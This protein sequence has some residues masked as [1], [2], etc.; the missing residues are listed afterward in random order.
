[1]SDI[2]IN[3]CQVIAVII[4]VILTY[5]GTK[6]I[7]FKKKKSIDKRFIIMNLKNNLNK[8]LSKKTLKV[9]FR[10]I[11][12][13]WI[14]FRFIA[15]QID[16]N[17]KKKQD[18]E[19]SSIIIQLQNIAV[20]QQDEPTSLSYMLTRIVRFTKYTKTAFIKM[21]SY[22]DQ[23]KEEEAKVAFI[24]EI[25]TPLARDLAHILIQLDSIKPVE[26]VKQLNA[27][28]ERVRNDNITT[29]N[30]KEELYSDI[31][32][33]MPTILCFIILMNFLKIILNIITNFTNI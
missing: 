12:N 9:S 28:E 20:S 15:K 29:K 31:M 5:L 16:L 14:P 23:A 11:N 3:I 6:F 22:V 17:L 27:L 1:M 19:L 33:I 7:F 8:K 4:F 13:H 21:I 26:V 18:I 24:N 2:K 30:Q 10:N 25:D 32:Y